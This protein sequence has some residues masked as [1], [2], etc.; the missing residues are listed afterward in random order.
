MLS[1]KMAL[2]ALVLIRSLTLNSNSSYTLPNGYFPVWSDIYGT[3]C[4]TKTDY[5]KNLK[6]NPKVMPTNEV[7]PV[8]AE[9]INN[10]E[11]N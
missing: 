3:A 6:F 2:P 7:N 4:E 1:K 11:S 10:N 5:L 8:L 9:R